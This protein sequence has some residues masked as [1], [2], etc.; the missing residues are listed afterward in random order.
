[1]QLVGN[2]LV[3]ATVQAAEDEYLLLPSAQLA[4][5]DTQVFEQLLGLGRVFGRA[6]GRRDALQHVQRDVFLQRTGLNAAR[7]QVVQRQVACSLVAL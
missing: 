6:D 2:L 7:T 1:M 3:A 5:A 4:E